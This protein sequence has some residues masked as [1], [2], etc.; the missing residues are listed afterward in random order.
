[1][2]NITILGIIF[3]SK[4]IWYNQRLRAIEKANKAKQALRMISGFFFTGEMIK[5]STALFYSRLYYGKVWLSSALAAPFKK[6]LWQASSK[7]L[8]I[9]QKDWNGQYSFKI[10]HK[11][12]KR[13]THKMWLNYSLW[14][15][16]CHSNRYS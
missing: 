1:M 12:S 5:L 2:K 7:M 16:S 4:P 11:M 15:V 6:K 8:K 9:C 13:A 3:D 14:N 10:L